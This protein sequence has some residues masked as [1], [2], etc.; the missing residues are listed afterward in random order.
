V[1]ALGFRNGFDGHTLDKAIEQVERRVELRGTVFV[2]GGTGDEINVMLAAAG[3][4]FKRMMNEQVK[5]IF[6]ALFGA[7]TIVHK[8]ATCHNEDRYN[9]TN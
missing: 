4:N 7:S 6:L 5:V 1:G 2:S 9:F 8:Q 3:F